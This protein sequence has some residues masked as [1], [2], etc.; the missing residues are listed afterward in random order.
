MSIRHK[1]A[2]RNMWTRNIISQSASLVIKKV[3]MTYQISKNVYNNN[4]IHFE[5]ASIDGVVT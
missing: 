5:E 3:E 2:R 4:N 1:K